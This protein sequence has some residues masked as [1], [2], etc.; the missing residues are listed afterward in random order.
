MNNYLSLVKMCYLNSAN[1]IQMKFK[2]TLLTIAFLIALSAC[3]KK[4][5][6]SLGSNVNQAAEGF[7]IANSDPAAIELVDSIMIAMGGRENWDKTRFISWNFFGNRDLVWDKALG[8]VR[9]DSRKDTIT[10]LVNLNTMEGRVRIKGQEIT[11]VDSLKKMLT[12]AKSIWINDSYWLVMPFKLMDPGVRIKY[13]G[14]E[15]LSGGMQCNVL[16]LTFDNVGDTPQNKYRLYVDMSDNLIKQ[17]AFYSQAI[18]DS[19]NFVRPWDNYRKY[20]DILLS[21][22]RSD[23]GGPR[24]V[25]VDGE[26]PDRIFTEF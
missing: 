17:W 12:K 2:D 19:S 3:E 13:M 5:T 14:E 9:I 4:E 10:Y 16:E 26:L 24:S 7:E 20:G 18:Q 21:A 1:R 23:G 22:D 25:K 11:E 8:R 6:K 15:K